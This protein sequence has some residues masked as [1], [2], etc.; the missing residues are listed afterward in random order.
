MTKPSEEQK[1]IIWA[2]MKMDAPQERFEREL[3][4]IFGIKVKSAI[5]NTFKQELIIKFV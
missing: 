1:T 3:S 2:L 5:W 4:K